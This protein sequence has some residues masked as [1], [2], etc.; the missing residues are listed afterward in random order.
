M[1]STG[2]DWEVNGRRMYDEKSINKMN[3]SVKVL[4]WKRILIQAMAFL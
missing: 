2:K 4:C 3:E 1:W